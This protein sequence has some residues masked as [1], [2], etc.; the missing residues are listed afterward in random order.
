MN[1]A[2]YALFFGL[3][4]AGLVY[5]KMGRRVGYGNSQNVW[6]IV[7]ISFFIAMFFFYSLFTWV[8]HL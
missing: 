6:L 1:S 8:I 2:L 3:G 7:G 5:S 4:V